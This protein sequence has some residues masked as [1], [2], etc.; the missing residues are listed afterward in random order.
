MQGEREE[1]ITD[2]DDK[3]RVEEALIRQGW[4]SHFHELLN[5]EGDRCIMPGIWST[6]RDT[7]I[8]G[9]VGV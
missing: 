9:D 8:L 5:E 7:V 4:Q 3:V 1:D 2:E 6:Q